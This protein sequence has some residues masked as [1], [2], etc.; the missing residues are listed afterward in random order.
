MVWGVCPMLGVCKVVY[1][2]SVGLHGHSALHSF[3]CV[4]V[5]VDTLY[6]YTKLTFHLHHTWHSSSVFTKLWRGCTVVKLTLYLY[7]TPSWLCLVWTYSPICPPVTR[8]WINLPV[9]TTYKYCPDSTVS[10]VLWTCVEST[11][12]RTLPYPR[13]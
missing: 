6:A 10:E 7:Q 9:G 13:Y 3:K 8:V 11:S 1:S 12:T 5:G 4:W 2:V